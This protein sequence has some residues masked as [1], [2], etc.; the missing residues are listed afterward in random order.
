MQ[1]ILRLKLSLFVSS[2]LVIIVAFLLLVQQPAPSHAWTSNWIIWEYP[3][4]VT[5]N[6]DSGSSANTISA[7]ASSISH[8]NSVQAK[9]DFDSA[10][11]D[12]DIFLSSANIDYVDWDGICTRYYSGG[13]I[14]NAIAR[15]NE[16]YTEG[17]T[18][19]NK[20]RSVSGHELGHSIGLGEGNYPDSLME[21]FTPTRWGTYGIYSPQQDDINGINTLYYGW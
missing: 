3:Q 9:V 15:L 7:W 13:Y 2:I 17:Y 21:Q 4:P 19:V 18:P 12:A 14:D 5:Y 10:I 16:H 11:G 20:R 8:W 6:I 1:K